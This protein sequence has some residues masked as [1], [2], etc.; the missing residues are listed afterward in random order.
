MTL[1]GFKGSG[2]LRC[3]GGNDVYVYWYWWWK[4]EEKTQIGHEGISTVAKCKDARACST[5]SCSNPP[6]A[7]TG[8]IPNAAASS[9]IAALKIVRRWS[10]VAY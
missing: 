9:P 10:P 3:E 5:A 4:L 2:I 7:S 8:Y 1:L 6:R